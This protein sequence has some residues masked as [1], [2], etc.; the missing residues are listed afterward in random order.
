MA[1]VQKIIHLPSSVGGMAWALSKGENELG[2]L[3]EVLYTDNS[4]LKYP[5]DKQVKLGSSKT[6]NSFKLCR[7][8]L[9]IRKK[10]DVFHFNFGKSLVEMNQF[11]IKLA[12]LPFYPKGK[13]LFMTFNGC[14]ARQKF[15]TMKRKKIAAC[16][17][18]KCYNGM[19]NS[20]RLDRK[21]ENNI[22]KATKYIDHMFA[23]NPDLL[24]FLP[25]EKSSFLPY[26]V[27][28]SV[29][30][31]IPI[32]QKKKFLIVHAPTQREAKGSDEI[33]KA[34]K[35]LQAEDSSI[36]FALIENTK[37]SEALKLYREAD[38]IIDQVK[39]G[40]YGAFA[41]ECMYMSKP[42]AVYIDKA[43]LFFIPKKMAQDL[44]NSVINITP[45]NILATLKEFI[46]DS[47][48]L[49]EI[50]GSARY[51]AHKWHSPQAVAKEVSNF[52]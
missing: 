26:A 35:S 4:W 10:Y 2:H 41:V 30:S 16:H 52:I 42:V 20:G 40:W 36:N 11:G 29:K 13:R 3:S 46:Y 50:G 17:N 5:C 43:D 25:P 7:E 8:F 6:I 38:L 51:F 49:R 32:T 47:Q 37:H 31:K 28:D 14:D 39:I 48:K 18:Q 15:K 9:A 12:E 1:K 44:E 22:L 33:I 45:D 21:R 27:V 19:C 34:V 24:Y 23:V